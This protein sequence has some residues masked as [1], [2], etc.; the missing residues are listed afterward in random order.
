MR[1]SL[2]YRL[3][4]PPKFLHTPFAGLEISNDAIRLIEYTPH[5]HG[6]AILKYDRQD[7]SAGI[8][9]DGEVKDEAKLIEL[10][11]QF[12]HKNKVSHVEV[13]VPEEKTYLFQTDIPSFNIDIIRQNIES[14]IEDNVPLSARD[15]EFYFNII[16]PVSGGP[17]RASVLVVSRSYIEKLISILRQSGLNPIAFATVPKAIA[18]A[19]ALPHTETVKIV[20]HIMTSSVG[21]Y[22]ISGD[23]VLF[24][25]T[26]PWNVAGASGDLARE[27][28]KVYSYWITR[29]DMPAAISG[30]IISGRGAATVAESLKTNSEIQLPIEM[31]DVWKNAFDINT[32]VPPISLADSLEYVVAAGL[33]LPTS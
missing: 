30:I 16:P 22:V 28:N 18:R 17:I 24:S 33:A 3:F 14:K 25:S 9:V 11:S 19:V 23:T 1:S 13:S 27:I 12:A 5:S 7:I 4:P 15:V 20:A 21:M 2:F 26:I 29:S 8:I 31:P 10:L 32:Y 6:L